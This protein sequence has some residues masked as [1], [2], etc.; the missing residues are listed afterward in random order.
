[1]KKTGLALIALALAFTTACGG[2]DRPTQGEVSKSLT[3]KSSVLPTALPKKQ[4]DCVAK[5]LEE[6]E[7]SDKTLEALVA[8]DKGYKGTTEENKILSGLS[9]KITRNCLGQ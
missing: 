1:M 3:N 2:N 4:A 8:Q 6:S 7:L 9:P 5:V